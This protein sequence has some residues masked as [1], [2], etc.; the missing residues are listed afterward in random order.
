MMQ[1]NLD[2]LSENIKASKAPKFNG[3]KTQG[4]AGNDSSASFK[5]LLS[6]LKESKTTGPKETDTKVKSPSKAKAEKTNPAEKKDVSKADKADRNRRADKTES[7]KD[8]S[9]VDD[10]AQTQA[11]QTQNSPDEKVQQAS[12]A[13]ENAEL[14]TELTAAQT[15]SVQVNFTMDVEQGKSSS[16]LELFAENAKEFV[17]VMGNEEALPEMSE[18]E[19]SLALTQETVLPQ[20]AVKENGS[21]PEQNTLASKDKAKTKTGLFAKTENQSEN[22]VLSENGSMADQ[23]E[24]GA[25]VPVQEAQS[26]IRVYDQRTQAPKQDV[27]F[28]STAQM[29][30]ESAFNPDGTVDVTYALQGQSQQLGTNTFSEIKPQGTN[31]QQML[32]QQVQANVPDFAKAGSI[33][34]KDNNQGIINLNLK[35][36]SLGNVKINLQ[37]SDKTVTGVIQV[38]SKEAMEAFKQNLD[39]F[40]ESFQ[41]QGF[42]NAS[43]TLTMS[44]DNSSNNFAGNGQNQ[45]MSNEYMSRKVYSDYSSESEAISLDTNSVENYVK[46]GDYYINVVA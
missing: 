40:R 45:N 38:A 21:N 30:A 8:V 31:F 18:E 44:N 20:E 23:L 15:E 27:R 6:N 7:K 3:P 10:L 4:I 13:L 43:F 35:P 32:T 25:E 5:D 17:S 33:I 12:M 16:D 41:Q 39:S 42:E 2:G 19:I 36:E 9:K 34:L 26:A 14:G 1:I 28:E 46:D 11:A 22:T 24:L 37:I 29:K